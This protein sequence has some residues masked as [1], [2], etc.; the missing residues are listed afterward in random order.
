MQIGGA[1]VL[2]RPLLSAAGGR[3]GGP[4]DNGQV[5]TA[6]LPRPTVAADGSEEASY[7]FVLP[8]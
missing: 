8:T 7:T 2:P 1:S 3:D 6:Q 4:Y 5:P